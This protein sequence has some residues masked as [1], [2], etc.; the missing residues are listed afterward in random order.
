MLL[1]VRSKAERDKLKID[2]GALRGVLLAQQIDLLDRHEQLLADY[3]HLLAI[4]LAPHDHLTLEGLSEAAR[5]EQVVAAQRVALSRLLPTERDS[6]AGAL[7]ML[8]SAMATTIQLKLRVADLAR[9][10]IRNNDDE[11]C[12]LRARVNEFDIPTLRMVHQAMAALA[13]QHVKV[14][15]PP[16]PPPP[17]PID[18]FA[19]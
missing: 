17:D 2:L 19:R 10:S 11:D 15:D 9:A 5:E 8:T 1:P 16:K 13:G 6:L 12:A 14:A 7:K 18:D 3:G 4:Y